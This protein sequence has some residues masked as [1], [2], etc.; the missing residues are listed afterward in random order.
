MVK[1]KGRKT[2]GY[3][4]DINEKKIQVAWQLNFSIVMIVILSIT[5][6]GFISFR[7]ISQSILNNTKQKCNSASKTDFKKCRDNIREFG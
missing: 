6:V 2:I 3:L 5:V 7:M 1:F 4:P